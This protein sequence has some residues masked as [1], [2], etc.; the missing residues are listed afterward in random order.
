MLFSIYLK[1]KIMEMFWLQSIF[2]RKELLEV[3]T[4]QTRYGGERKYLLCMKSLVHLNKSEL[5]QQLGKKLYSIRKPFWFLFNFLMN[6][7]NC[8]MYCFYWNSFSYWWTWI[9]WIFQKDEMRQEIWETN[10]LSGFVWIVR[11]Y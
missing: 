8:E 11:K 3:I 9:T 6:F 7:N 1:L 10:L 4:S 5:F 2:E